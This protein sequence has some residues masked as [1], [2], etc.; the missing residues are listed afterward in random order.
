[1][2]IAFFSNTYKPV[3]NG[4]VRSMATFREEL[5]RQGHN[6][7]VFA[8]NAPDYEDD[9]PFIFR[10]P[11][12]ELPVQQVPFTIPVSGFVDRLLPSLKLDVI[13]AHHPILMGRAAARKAEELDLP[14][15]FTHHT[16]YKE[17][18]HYFALPQEFVKD[19][20]E[21][22]IGDY[23]AR[24]D[25]VI[26][27]SGSVRDLL[28]ETYGIRG[29][30][31]VLPTGVNTTHFREGDGSRVRHERGWGD[32]KVLISVGRLALE[33]N[34][35]TMLEAMP[36]VLTRHPAAR[37]VIL[38]GGPDEKELR[39]KAKEL[40]ISEHVEFV[41]MVP[42]ESVP[43][44]L[45]AADLFVFAS[46][47][48]TQG[49]VTLEAMAAGL[50]VVAV[51]GTGTADVVRPGQDGLLTENSSAT[52]AEGV[53]RLLNDDDMRRAFA[54]SAASRAKDFS[55]SRQAQSLLAIYEAAGEAHRAGR[56]M[57]ID[58]RKPIFHFDWRQR[59]GLN[60]A[61]D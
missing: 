8:Q 38:G 44:Y 16:R 10:Y 58:P 6:V 59:L 32:D 50:P 35:E 19:V 51:D 43:D 60:P 13:H 22:W 27:P 40:G 21:R 46:I 25:H 54:E 2:H 11:A 34:W 15:V 28:V 7:F 20:I 39:E 47:T 49:L 55:I 33:K 36:A 41:G 57:G 45:H 18:S 1:M 53:L 17:Y 26:V 24:C 31:T 9:E 56:K 23:M 12:F 3:I 5:S 37:L 48:E 29:E 61:A 4:V 30:V 14:L 52:L 42:F